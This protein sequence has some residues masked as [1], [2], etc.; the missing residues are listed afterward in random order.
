MATF[1]FDARPPEEAV[2]YLEQKTVGGRFSFDWRDVREAEHLNAFVAAKAMTADLLADLHGGLVSA[3]ND[4]WTR[5]RYIAELEPILQRKGWW[6]RRREVDPVT[7]AEELV[8]LGTPRRLKVIYDTNMRMAHASGR[9]ERFSRSAETRPFIRYNH[10]PQE[11]PRP[12]HEA[13]HGITLPI[14]H[15]MWQTHACPNGWG[16]KCFLTSH[17][18]GVKVTTED[19][20]VAKGVY[21]TRPWRNTRTGVVEEVPDG[22]DPGFAYNVGQA[23]MAGLAPPP[24]PEAQRSYVQGDRLPR[25]LPP[26]PVP[27][28]LPPDV[29][30]RPD[31]EGVTDPQRVFEALADVLSVK[32]GQV[33]MDR[34]QVPLVM[35]RRMFQQHDG[36]GAP[37]GPKTGLGSRAP[38][39]EIFAAVIRDPDEIWHSLQTREDG[40]SVLVR[41]LIG[42][43]D[44][45]AAGRQWFVVTF[46]EGSSRGVWMGT[47]A[48]PPGKTNR[49]R[50]QEATAAAGHR[51]GTL[52]YRRT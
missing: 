45:G 13:W 12:L 46:H 21:R 7:G 27:R 42:V 5:E 25:S 52:V 8:T 48:Y 22:I 49:I 11:N 32:E 1:V 9:W 33:Y 44:A 50:T 18:A 15:P 23:R 10:T 2:A 40:S 3:I 28:P 4:G 43:F 41:N 6:G 30:V 24:L 34:A 39:A 29:D 38:L 35:G 51:V 37:T 16:C 14:G 36:T 31:L 17:R 26:A 20:L 19:E 47:T